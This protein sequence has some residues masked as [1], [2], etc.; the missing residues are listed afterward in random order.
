MNHNKIFKF[1]TINEC[2]EMSFK[3]LEKYVEKYQDWDM[4]YSQELDMIYEEKEL[5]EDMK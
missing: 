4:A 1:K 5:M 3:K 2:K